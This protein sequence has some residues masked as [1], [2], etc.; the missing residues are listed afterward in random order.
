MPGVYVLQHTAAETL[1]TIQDALTDAGRE[2]RYVR[3]F[4]GDSVPAHLGGVEG[5]ILMG[6]PMGVRD[7]ETHPFLRQEM[8]LVEQALHDGKPV[9][10]VCLGSQL[11][12]AALGA[13]VRRAQR[14]EIGWYPVRWS[15]A[16]R[17]DRLCGGLPDT[18]TA[19]HW[20]G[21]VFDLPDGA[22]SLASSD[23]TSH[24]AYRF[25]ESAYGF[26]FHME[27]TEEMVREMIRN[28]SGQM[29]AEGLSGEDLY[30]GVASHLEPLSRIAEVVFGRWAALLGKKIP[31]A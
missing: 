1:G 26:L 11:L 9:L 21:D 23:R 4:L 17:G 10:G 15:E 5:L 22:V 8:R 28:F 29:R 18:F 6:G 25:G 7:A 16:A 2:A 13:P 31:R 24:Q 27:I 30:A 20:H 12:A 3:P 19:F 14:G